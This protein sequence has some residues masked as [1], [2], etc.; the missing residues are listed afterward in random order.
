MTDPVEGN[1]EIPPGEPLLE[2]A[3][4]IRRL[5]EKDGLNVRLLQVVL[6]GKNRGGE[7]VE[8]PVH[9]GIKP[10]VV[11]AHG[12]MQARRCFEGNPCVPAGRD[13][14]CRIFYG[15]NVHG[16]SSTTSHLQPH[17][18]AGRHGLL[19]VVVGHRRTQVRKTLDGAVGARGQL[20]KQ[21]KLRRAARDELAV[22]SIEE[23]HKVRLRRSDQG[24]RKGHLHNVHLRPLLV[25]GIEG[26]DDVQ[27]AVEG[28]EERVRVVAAGPKHRELI[29]IPL[30]KQRPVCGQVGEAADREDE[31]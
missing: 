24:I 28:R 11:V 6:G 1:G 2:K 4:V 16:L 26:L 9:L 15:R 14:G 22:H 20:K 23:G 13:E 3:E 7:D 18:G 29:G 25:V 8:E 31:T 19:A 5:F 12:M 21:I 17:Q 10:V 30:L 27:V